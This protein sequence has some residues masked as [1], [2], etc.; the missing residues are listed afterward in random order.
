MS[1]AGKTKSTIGPSH[2]GGPKDGFFTKPGERGLTTHHDSRAARQYDAPGEPAH[3]KHGHRGHPVGDV[4]NGKI[5]HAPGALDIQPRAGKPKELPPV[6]YHVSTTARQI[7]AA[8]RGGMGHPGAAVTDGGQTITTS[9]AAAPML[10]AYGGQLP[11]KAHMKPA[12]VA[13]SMKSAPTYGRDHAAHGRRVLGGALA[14]SDLNTQMAHGLPDT[15][16]EN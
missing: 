11:T 5:V 10:D 16:D 8:G 14:A 12:P 3:E 6:P 13:D 7:A 4:V 1:V 2:T 15:T 9:A